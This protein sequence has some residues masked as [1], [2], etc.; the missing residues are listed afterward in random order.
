MP[1][2]VKHLSKVYGLPSARVTE[3]LRS[4]E[5]NI[6]VV[7]IGN[8]GLPVAALL[9]RE[10]ANV[11]GVRRNARLVDQINMGICPIRGEPGLDDMIRDLV[12]RGKLRATTDAESAARASDVIIIL[13]PLL[14]DSK[15]RPDFSNI[16]KACGSVSKGLGRGDLVIVETTMPPGSTRNVIAPALSASGLKPGK[17][18][19]LVHAPERLMTGRVIRNMYK[20]P[21]IIGGWDEKSVDAAVGLFAPFGEVVRVSSLEA[22]ELVKISEGVYRDLNIAYAN[23]LALFCEKHGVNVWEVVE[24]ANK[25][26]SDYCHIHMPGSGVGG[27]CIPVYPHFLIEKGREYGVDTSLIRDARRINDSMPRHMKELIDMCLADQGKK[28]SSSTVAVLGIAF[29]GGVKETRFSPGISL[30]KLLQGYRDVVVH[31]PMFPAEEITKMGMKPATLEEALSSDCIAIVTAHREYL[32]AA[33][34]LRGVSDRVVD[35]RNVLPQAKYR[36]GDLT[37]R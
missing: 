15:G 13:V 32:E 2:Q 26:T 9:A 31:D 37:N 14:V 21:K 11:I 27:H 23:T 25:G 16:L 19:G 18:F 12:G 30:V 35:G 22:A 7:G 29:R 6:D 5:L 1:S 8:M 4:G 10:G 24:A 20:Y 34:L 33:D 36:I 17:D 28:P 3:L